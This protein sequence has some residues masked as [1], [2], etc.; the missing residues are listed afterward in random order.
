MVFE[1]MKGDGIAGRVWED[2]THETNGQF[3]FSPGTHDEGERRNPAIEL[4]G[5]SD[6]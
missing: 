1:P 6:V 2:T 3:Q 5:L 4:T